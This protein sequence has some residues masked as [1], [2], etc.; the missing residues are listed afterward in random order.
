MTRQIKDTDTEE[1]MIEALKDI[2]KDNG[3]ISSAEFRHAI[4]NMEEKFPEEYLDEM[5]RVTEFNGAGQINYEECFRIIKVKMRIL[6]FVDWFLF[7]FKI[8]LNND[9]IQCIGWGLVL[10]CDHDHDHDHDHPPHLY[11]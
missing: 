5:I 8:T 3:F 10:V 2:N 11:Y 1:K 4:L 9:F 7:I 6:P